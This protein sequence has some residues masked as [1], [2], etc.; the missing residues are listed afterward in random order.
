VLAR[1]PVVLAVAVR[2]V[3][4]GEQGIPH[5]HLQVRGI[6]AVLA[7]HYPVTFMLAVAAVQVRLEQMVAPEMGVLELQIAYLVLP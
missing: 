1:F 5:Q 4:W 3:Y 2:Q 6:T 7:E